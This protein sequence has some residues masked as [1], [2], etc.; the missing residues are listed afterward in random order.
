MELPAIWS[1]V[2]AFALIALFVFPSLVR[3]WRARPVGD[4]AEDEPYKVY[5]TEFDQVI[6]VRELPGKLTSISPDASKKFLEPDD[7]AWKQAV[8]HFRAHCDET[9]M[10]RDG[11][12]S[13][14]E[15]FRDTA[16]FVLVDQSGSM[17]GQT[18]PWVVAGLKLVAEQLAG[19]GAVTM[20][21]GYTTAG[22]HGG[23]ARQKWIK[24]GR[25]ARPGRLCALNHIIYKTFSDSKF[26]DHAARAMLNPDLLRE[27]IDGEA[28]EWAEGIL[29][30]R[31]ETR[32]VLLI[33][34]DGAPVDDSTLTQNGPSFLFRHV[35]NVIGRIEC[36]N[37]IEICAVGIN[38]RVS[39]FYA[40][41]SMVS[42]APELYAAA[43]Q[44]L[45]NTS[46]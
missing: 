18:M 2:T 22:W 31:S 15:L 6:D 11:S 9:L 28:I 21:A 25:P 33:I 5:T 26:D 20:I 19:S 16:I 43:V 40:R 35:E 29:L 42:N 27:N 36:E 4:P 30:A 24:S 10:V 32:K 3:K 46:D 41:S 34:S 37:K 39:E 38:F 1:F 44:L 13:N 8:E 45:T 14:S 17:K 7:K 12:I 23:F